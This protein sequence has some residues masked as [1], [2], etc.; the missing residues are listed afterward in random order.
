MEVARPLVVVVVL[1]GAVAGLPHEELEEGESPCLHR[2]CV[3]G[4]CQ[5]DPDLVQGYRCFCEDGYTGHRWS[6]QI[7][8]V[9]NTTF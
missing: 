7:K 1:V 3:H 9:Q 8:P 6:A 4:V 5:E 2:P